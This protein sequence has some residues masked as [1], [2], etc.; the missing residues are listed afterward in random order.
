MSID[1]WRYFKKTFI[2]Y[3]GIGV[4]VSFLRAMNIFYFQ[5]LLNEFGTNLNNKYLLIYGITIIV[6]P[7]LAYLEQKPS[8][9]L[10]KGIF[11]YLKKWH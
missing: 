6:V 9:K 2:I 11:F 4:V 8:T 1:L 7:I 10:Q 3:I 5:K